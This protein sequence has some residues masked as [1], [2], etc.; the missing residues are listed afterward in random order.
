MK[1]T[2]RSV[3]TGCVMYMLSVPAGAGIR[4]FP[5][6]GGNRRANLVILGD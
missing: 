2:S 5:K 1:E 4:D 6:T 3:P